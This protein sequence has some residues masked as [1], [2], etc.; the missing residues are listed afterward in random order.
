MDCRREPEGDLMD[1]KEKKPD[2]QTLEVTVFAPR[3][4]EGRQ[5]SWS[6]HASVGEAAEEVAEA[7]GY[8]RGKP[9]LAKAGV[10][11]D[12]DKQLVAAGVRDGDE[13]ELVDVG[14]GV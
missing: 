13:L 10:A 8:E 9:T 14:G 1:K 4:T 3:A 2:K 6:K 7:F 5:F 12:R 11:L